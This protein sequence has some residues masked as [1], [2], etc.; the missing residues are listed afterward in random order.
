MASSASLDV[1]LNVGSVRSRP[2]GVKVPDRL[3][4]SFSSDIS[5]AN[6]RPADCHSVM[7]LSYSYGKSKYRSWR[8]ANPLPPSLPS[9]ELSE[10]AL[11]G[12]NASNALKTDT[13]VPP[14]DDQSMDLGSM[15]ERA[16]YSTWYITDDAYP[17]QRRGTN[18]PNYII[19]SRRFLNSNRP[20]PPVGSRA[21]KYRSP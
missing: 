6:L 13:A 15:D 7:R 4:H 5:R 9:G 20:L 11:I 21:C 1:L 10:A 19:L 8:H 3:V 18:M 2:R 17:L 12:K 16:H 14:L